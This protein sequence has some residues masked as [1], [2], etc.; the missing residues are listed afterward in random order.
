MMPLLPRYTT[1]ADPAVLARVRE[2]LRRVEPQAARRWGTM[3]SHE[4][5]CHLSDIFRAVLREREMSFVR[6]VLVP[7]VLLTWWALWVPLPWPHGFPTRSEADPR[8]RGTRPGDF[9]RDLAELEALVDRVT[10]LGTAPGPKSW[11]L[12]PL[13]G[14]LTDREWLRWSYLHL[15]HHLR[16]FG[17]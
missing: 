3:T 1:L 4:M 2:R 17:G 15:D 14:A 5:L 8:R 7:R 10:A 12:H 9:A 6:R 16:Q 11:G 13:F